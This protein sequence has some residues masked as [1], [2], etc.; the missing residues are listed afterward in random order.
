MNK[1]QNNDLNFGFKS[2]EEIHSI[3]EEELGKL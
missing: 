3:L 2:K 1:I